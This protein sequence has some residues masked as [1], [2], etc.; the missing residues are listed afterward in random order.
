MYVCYTLL[1]RYAQ[2]GPALLYDEMFISMDESMF[3]WIFPRGQITLFLD[4]NTVIGVT[5]TFGE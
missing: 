2:I 1:I 3:G 4:T 5:T